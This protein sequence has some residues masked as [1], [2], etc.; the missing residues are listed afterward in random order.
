MVWHAPLYIIVSEFLLSLPLVWMYGAAVRRPWPYSAWLGLLA[1]VWMIPSVIVAWW[2][3]GPCRPLF[4]ALG[5][6]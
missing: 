4:K 1:G 6:G 5:C 2:L 3:V